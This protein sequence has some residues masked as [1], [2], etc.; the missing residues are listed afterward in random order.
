MQQFGVIRSRGGEGG[1]RRN[2]NNGK[3]D[4]GGILKDRGM[5]GKPI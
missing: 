4:I 2:N 5:R 1:T 3:K